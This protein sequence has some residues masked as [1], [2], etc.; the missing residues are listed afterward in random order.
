MTS[1]RSWLRLGAPN[2]GRTWILRIVALSIAAYGVHSWV[3]VGTGSRL[4]AEMT[5]SFWNFE[6][7]ALRFF[8][9]QSAV[10]GLLI[11]LA[12]YTTA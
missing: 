9:H 6:E 12:H 11:F 5:M 4:I 3:V 8:L 2:A 7:A 1:M 10:A